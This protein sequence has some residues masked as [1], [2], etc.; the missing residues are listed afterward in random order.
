V[1]VV[2]DGAVDGVVTATLDQVP[3][4]TALTRLLPGGVVWGRAGE[5]YV[6]TLADPSSSA[7]AAIA[8]SEVYRPHHTPAPELVQLLPPD[9]TRFVRVSAERNVVA[10]SG[11][12]ALLRRIARELRDLDVAAP[13]IEIEAIICELSPYEGLETGFDLQHG[14]PLP[15]GKSGAFSLESLAAG[16]VIAPPGELGAESFEFYSAYVRLL[17]SEGYVAIRA[18]PRVRVQDG[19]PAQILIGDL[20]YFTVSQ[21]K[22]IFRELRTIETGIVLDL[23]AR[24]QGDGTIAVKIDRAEVSDDIRPTTLVPSPDG[25][26]PTVSTRRVRTSVTVVDGATVVIGGLVRKRQ[27]E[28]SVSLPLLGDIPLLGELFRR[29]DQ[30]EEETEVAIFLTARVVS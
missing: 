30:R 18:A 1:A 15:G 9:L 11:T 23:S 24:V 12:P 20:S 21:G 25:T 17:A 8:R 10:S 16:G 14:V 5:Q 22:E 26:L 4:E 19:A 27:V 3:F 7:F 6:V 2:V 29:R 28:R 13:E